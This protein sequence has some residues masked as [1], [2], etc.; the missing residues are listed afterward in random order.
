M[1]F[2]PRFSWYL[3]VFVVIF[4]LL[5]VNGKAQLSFVKNTYIIT[6]FLYY[7]SVGWLLVLFNRQLGTTVV[8]FQCLSFSKYL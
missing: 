7:L 2:L 5:N 3:W 1:L 4:L 6:I 8:K